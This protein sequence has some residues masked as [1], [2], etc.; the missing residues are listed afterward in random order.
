MRRYLLI[1]F[2]LL[3]LTAYAQEI[4]LKGTIIS[5]TDHEPMIGTTVIVQ[6]TTNGSVT[7]LDGNYALKGVPSNATVIYS[8]IGYKTRKVEV[9]NRTVI[10]LVMEEDVE[11]LDEVV[12]VGYGSVKKSD[13]T[14]SISTV[15]GDDLKTM[16]A[17]NAM[18]ALQ[19]KA[20]GVQVTSAGGPGAAPRVIIR[21]VTTVNG[22]DPL[23]VVDGMPVGTNINFLNQD[24]I[25]SIEVLKD[26]SSA[27][28]YGTRGS[29]GVILVTT[30]KGHEGKMKFQFNTSV[31]FLTLAK[32]DMAKASEY[33]KVFKARYTNDNSVPVWNGKDNI[34]NTEGTDWWN[35]VVK[36]VA[37]MQNYNFS[38]QGG[39]DKISYSASIGYFR[40]DSHYDVGFW[41]KLTARFNTEYKF[42][43]IVKAGIDLAPKWEQWDDT[44]SLLGDVMR[45]DPTT[46]VFRPEE[47]WTNNQYDNYARSHNSLVW[48]PVGSVARLNKSSDEYGLLA[49]PYISVEPIA[50]LTFR[51][52]F[53]VN[54]RFRV[55]DT[56]DPKFHIDNLEER[57]QSFVERKMDNWVDWNW[58]NTLSYLK[59]FSKKHNVNLMAGY[60]MEKFSEYWLKGSRENTPSNL[61]ELQYVSAGTLNQKAEGTNVYTT[62]VS[63]LGRAMYNYD[64]RYYLTGSI[65]VDGSS[66]FPAANKYATF[67]ALS[68]AWRI[69]GEPFMQE[70]TLFSNLKLRAGWGRVGN[71]SID[72]AAYLTLVGPSD[73]VFGTNAQRNLGTSVSTIGNPNLRWETVEDFN[74]GLD[75]GFFDGR[76]SVTADVYQRKSTDMLLK[77]DNLLV[78]GYPMW[79]GQMWENV[80]SLKATGWELSFNY[81]DNISDLKYEVGLN[82]SSVKNKAVKL[83]GDTPILTGG[84]NGDYIIRNEQG[85]EISRFYG[86][87]VDGIFQNQAEV[88]AHTGEHGEI[89]Q[90]NA[91][92]GDLRFKDLNHDGVLDDKDKSFLGSAFPDLMLGLNLHLTYKDFDLVTNFYGTI[93]NDIY[94]KNKAL[95]GGEGGS[96]VYAGSYNKAWHGEGTSYD[97]PRL[98]VNDANNNYKRVSS[99]FVED[100]SYLR[101]KLL[102]LGYTI[103]KSISRQ[104]GVR[105]SLSAQNLFTITNY[106]GMDPERASM[107]GVT[108]AGI[109]DTGYPNPRTFLVGVNLTF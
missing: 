70:Q 34:T 15:K 48:N 85:G 29:N 52:Q 107:G 50:G 3:A 6:G 87:T 108:E 42:N 83:F 58:T 82:L 8:A 103:P 35:T 76:L 81:N 99:F 21:G 93:G 102:Q 36:D 86:Y 23:Y 26:A 77:K 67:P 94:N 20:N 91:V 1:L 79:N 69:T 37:L 96:N 12:V 25:E 40:Q 109:D 16:T 74:L 63:Y 97:I 39:T 51:S 57:K 4:N 31:G 9:K 55:S 65:R 11:A 33:E 27:A 44:P 10:N 17:G 24:D 5:A 59:T 66:K 100:G 71:Q 104:V 105:L 53:G 84:F 28:I 73:Y 47:E 101:C 80:G 19:G 61:D 78:L 72:N 68:G 13:L 22:S 60:T 32:P 64:N 106:S 98:S 89:L 30:K 45:M 88:N 56:F 49:N 92:P 62:L 2:G 41:D 43:K 7:D 38:F 75:L 95:Y 46:P 54:A 18:L 90:P 14:S